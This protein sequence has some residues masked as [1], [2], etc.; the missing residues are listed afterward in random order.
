M[1]KAILL[2]VSI[3]L[4][5]YAK[6]TPQDFVRKYNRYN[7]VC[8]GIGY[9]KK[10]C[11]GKEK[12]I[13][14]HARL[15]KR[16]ENLGV[17]VIVVFGTVTLNSGNAYNPTTGKFTA[18]D[19]GLYAFQWTILT[20]VGSCFKTEIVHNGKVI[21]FGHAEGKT[22]SSNYDSASSSAIIKM[23]RN[24]NVWI[25]TFGRDG[26]FAYDNWSSFSGFKL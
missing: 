24:D 5:V 9:E 7:T 26:K 15:T 19:D 14:F 12:E 10:N 23:K 21:G 2:V 11:T 13:A 1:M 4:E 20:N 18:P 6:E 22:G 8:Q 25:R 3:L 17:N 16:Q